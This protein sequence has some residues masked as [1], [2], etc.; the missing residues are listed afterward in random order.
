[1]ENIITRCNNCGHVHLSENW[2][3]Y[4]GSPLL[5]L[6]RFCKHCDEVGALQHPVQYVHPSDHICVVDA[7][8]DQVYWLT[9][10]EAR[11]MIR[12]ARE[13]EGLNGFH[14]LDLLSAREARDIL[15][16]LHSVRILLV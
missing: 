15:N 11:E 13:E 7:N 16:L 1:M 2:S 4:P 5:A 14:L 8:D 6:V 10:H 9:E 12:F 3:F